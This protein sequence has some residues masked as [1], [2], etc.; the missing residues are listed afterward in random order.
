MDWVIAGLN[1]VGAYLDDVVV[2]GDTWNEHLASLH[3][4]MG[5]LQK[6][7]LTINLRKCVFGK[8]TVDYLGHA[9]GGG[10]VR[11]KDA[12]V[13]SILS[14]PTP[15]TRKEV[16]SFLGMSRYYRRFCSNFADIAAPLTSLVS[17]K[18]PFSWTDDCNTAF[19][20]RKLFLSSHPVLH[21]PDY[22]KPFHLQIDASGVG[23]GGVLLQESGD[24]L[25]PIAYFSTK[26][27]SYQCNYSTIEKEGLA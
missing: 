4:L 8:G 3:L 5:R 24:I 20:N 21:T 17:K 13:A 1:G 7:G 11:P 16:M 25:H 14:S 9:I 23:V 6:A 26:L 19:H 12:N 10:R 2:T 18:V 27:K 15:T 22:T